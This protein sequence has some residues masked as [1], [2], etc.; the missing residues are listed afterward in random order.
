MCALV[1]ARVLALVLV[2]ASAC[3]PAGIIVPTPGPSPS[4]S[5]P[6][7]FDLS[8]YQYALQ[9]KARLRIA[10]AE[11]ASPFSARSGTAWSGFDTDIGRE[12]AKAIFGQRAD[13]DTFIEWVPV[14]AATRV[15]ALIDN[16]VDVVIQTFAI[17]AET[18]KRVDFSD[19]YF[20]TGGRVMVRRSDSIAGL[21]ELSEKTVCVRRGSGI[22]AGVSQA[23]GG[24]AKILSL[25]DDGACL[26]ALQRGQTDAIAADE[27]VLLDLVRQDPTTRMVGGYLTQASYAVGIKRNQSGDRQGFLP[28]VDTT[29]A[30]IVRD[31]TWAKLY[32]KHIAPLS[33]DHKTKPDG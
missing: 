24:F 13:I 10:T 28:F 21:G 8:T 3:G 4:A 14:T 11:A 27:A 15:A 1:R 19:P 32:E 6:P 20:L 2:M 26:L 18:A 5:T 9:T 7:R 12:I 23:T 33:G 16:K 22:E 17:D 31:G 30:A 25:S 29:L